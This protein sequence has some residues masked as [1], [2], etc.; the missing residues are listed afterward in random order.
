MDLINTFNYHMKLIDNNFNFFP[1]LEA[2][3]HLLS[4][5]DLRTIFAI[6]KITF[7]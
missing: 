6:K 5:K 2:N 4:I 7:H 3:S 1:L